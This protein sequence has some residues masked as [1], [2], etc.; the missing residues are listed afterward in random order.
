MVKS[1]LEDRSHEPRDLVDLVIKALIVL[2]PLKYLRAATLADV[3]E[4]QIRHVETPGVRDSNLLLKQRLLPLLP[5]L[6]LRRRR[7]LFTPGVGLTRVRLRSR[8]RAEDA[9]AKSLV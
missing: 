8:R 9:V 5:L 1:F 3:Y 6:R 7:R 4:H 2:K